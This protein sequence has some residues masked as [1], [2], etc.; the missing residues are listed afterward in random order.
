MR[1]LTFP[2]TAH[3]KLPWRA[4]TALN[5]KSFRVRRSTKTLEDV[6]STV[7]MDSQRSV[8]L[9][10]RPLQQLLDSFLFHNLSVAN[11]LRGLKLSTFQHCLDSPVSMLCNQEVP[12]KEAVASLA[13][14]HMESLRQMMS[15]RGYVEGQPSVTL[16]KRLLLDDDFLREQVPALVEDVL[17]YHQKLCVAVRAIHAV[18]QEI[19][20]DTE[21]LVG[22]SLVYWYVNALQHDTTA[23]DAAPDDG[24]GGMPAAEACLSIMGVMASDALSGLLRTVLEHLQSPRHVAAPGEKPR[25]A[26]G[27]EA[28]A[29]SA[30]G[31]EAGG[32]SAG[33]FATDIAEIQ[34]LLKRLAEQRVSRK[35][36]SQG[37][38]SRTPAAGVRMVDQLQFDAP[39]PKAAL[40]PSPGAAS[41]SAPKGGAAQRRRTLLRG[42]PAAANPFHALRREVVGFLRGFFTR[43]LCGPQHLPLHE[44]V[45][46][47]DAITEPLLG[48]PRVA[49]QMALSR[50]HRSLGCPC[51]PHA[52]DVTVDMP[53]VVI[54]YK[55][56]LECGRLVNLYDWLQ[57][58]VA[59]VGDP[60][61]EASP[62][63][64]ARF[65]RAASELQVLGFVQPSRR[66]TDHVARLTWGKM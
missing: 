27:G 19:P 32:D 35:E 39:G 55:L 52:E 53:D 22:K 56:H 47:N 12:L 5:T 34:A 51:P 29:A 38:V 42:A 49:V 50:P 3:R 18:A 66:K 31:D 40:A 60:D 7:M 62:A 23:G 15:F 36:P 61:A 1:S 41:G 64:Q 11:F 63:L 20:A 17:L 10:G 13:H 14:E 45:F 4:I 48:R 2:S 8:K 65:I 24:N 37:P 30:T 44:V 58:F 33:V 59:V 28:A 46:F 6:V 9:G 21:G 54:A 25:E 16:Q 57:A 26:G 43:N